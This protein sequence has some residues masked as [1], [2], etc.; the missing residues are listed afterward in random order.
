MREGP[1]VQIVDEH[2]KGCD[3]DQELVDALAKIGK[4]LVR[5]KDRDENGYAYAVRSES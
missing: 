2:G 5:R 3:P 1:I 4:I